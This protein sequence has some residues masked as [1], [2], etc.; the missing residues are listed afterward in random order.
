[1]KKRIRKALKEFERQHPKLFHGGHGVLHIG[2]FCGVFVQ[3]HGVYAYFALPLAVI[4]AMELL[5][6]HEEDKEHSEDPRDEM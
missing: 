6:Y 4:T 5:D 2:Y 1:M 3:G